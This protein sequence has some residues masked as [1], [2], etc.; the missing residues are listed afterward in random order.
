MIPAESVT[1]LV[2]VS[3]TEV[4]EPIADTIHR[5]LT[6]ESIDCRGP[7]ALLIGV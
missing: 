7:P 2:P 4:T 3:L 6:I 5:T 1:S